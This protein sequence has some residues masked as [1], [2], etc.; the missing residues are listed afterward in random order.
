MSGTSAHPNRSWSS[1]KKVL[2]GWK[3]GR[4]IGRGDKILL[5]DERKRYSAPTMRK[6]EPSPTHVPDKNLSGGCDDENAPSVDITKGSFNVS[7]STARKGMANPA[8]DGDTRPKHARSINSESIE[9]LT[10]HSDMRCFVMD[11]TP[12]A[13]F[14]ES[15]LQS[16]NDDKRKTSDLTDIDEE[17]ST[18]N[19]AYIPHQ[20]GSKDI[21][22][23][24]SYLHQQF[25]F[26]H[27]KSVIYSMIWAVTVLLISAVRIV[28]VNYHD[29]QE[30]NTTSTL[31][32]VSL[33]YLES[34]I[35]LI[36]IL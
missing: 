7:S 15:L 12:I 10:L 24:I 31:D 8:H 25:L 4:Q 28:V 3:L 9:L 2:A 6:H 14:C 1:S 21:E 34:K 11:E 26:V 20:P 23:G 19:H 16:L 17:K 13:V 32:L 27:Q 18:R 35:P 33:F 30:N 36:I 5:R 22:M 29:S